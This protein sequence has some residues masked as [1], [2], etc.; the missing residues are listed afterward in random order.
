MGNGLR[1]QSVRRGF[2]NGLVVRGLGNGLLVAVVTCSIPW[3]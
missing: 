3:F 2:G 1:R